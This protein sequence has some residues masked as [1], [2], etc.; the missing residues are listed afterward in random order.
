MQPTSLSSSN[1]WS[2]STSSL[3]LSSLAWL[4]PSLVGTLPVM[5]IRVAR[6]SEPQ[7]EPARARQPEPD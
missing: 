3:R 7:A 4:C 6:A 1:G 2:L 5:I